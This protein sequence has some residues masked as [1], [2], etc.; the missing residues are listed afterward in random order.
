MFFKNKLILRIFKLLK[1]FEL[2]MCVI[3]PGLYKSPAP[4]GKR[5]LFT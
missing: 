3:V 5:N 4:I 1:I 2:N